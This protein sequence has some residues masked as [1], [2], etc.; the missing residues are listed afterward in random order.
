M[1]IAGSIKE[2]RELIE[3]ILKDLPK[4][5]KGNKSAAQRVR[6]NTV[7]FEKASKSYRRD[8]IE[9]D[10]AAEKQKKKSAKKKSVE[11]KKKK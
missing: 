3:E 6:V 5:E 9:Q 2:M 7:S 10:K 8:T 4:A 11:R 1:S